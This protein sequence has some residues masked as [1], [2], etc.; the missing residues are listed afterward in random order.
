[1]KLGLG[2]GSTAKH[3]VT[4]VGEAYK[5]GALKNLMCVPTSKATEEHARSLGLP[6]LAFDDPTPLDLA[7]DGADEVDPHTNLIKGGG[8]A[9]LREKLVELRAK[10]FV[11]IVD[12]AKLSKLGLLFALPVEVKTAA[13]KSMADYL[14]ALGA[15]ATLRGG[16]GSAFVTDNGNHSV[17]ARFP[18]GIDAPAQLAQR[19]EQQAGVVGHGLFLNMAAEVVVGLG[20]GGVRRIQAPAR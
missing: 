9:L 13:W 15:V 7:V 6:L 10:R 8:G 20:S 1:M 11:V 19:L 17:D 16:E 3:F 5:A 14:G 4:A 2:T 12:E 18:H